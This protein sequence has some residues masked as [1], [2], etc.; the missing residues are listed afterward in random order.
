VHRPFAELRQTDGEREQGDQDKGRTTN[1]KWR[2][3]NRSGGQ[4][5]RFG[6]GILH[7]ACFIYF[8]LRGR[9]LDSVL[10]L[11]CQTERIKLKT[12]IEIMAKLLGGGLAGKI[13]GGGNENPLI[14]RR[15]SAR[16]SPDKSLRIANFK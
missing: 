15:P 8:R 4:T 9:K 6:S 11:N 14:A 2:N 10:N 3:E 13:A 1:E 5:P 16:K 12:A 7:F